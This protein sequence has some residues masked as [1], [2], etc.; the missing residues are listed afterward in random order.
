MYSARAL[1]AGGFG[2]PLQPQDA[3]S[4]RI[5]RENKQFSKNKQPKKH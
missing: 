1:A 2:V 4:N 3:S 5:T